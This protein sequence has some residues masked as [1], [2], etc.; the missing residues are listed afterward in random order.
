[1]TLRAACQRVIEPETNVRAELLVDG[2][3]FALTAKDGQVV[4]RYGP[5]VDADVVL[6]TA[7]E[8]MMALADGR[9]PLDQ[10][11][12]HVALSV[13]DTAKAEQLTSLLA[14]AMT[15]ITRDL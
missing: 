14:R 8:P 15:L 12:E 3:R 4:V 2:E 9:L 11:A 1:M 7:Y 10:F 5:A 13:E 6:S